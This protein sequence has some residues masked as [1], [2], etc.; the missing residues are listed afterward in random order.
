MP[1]PRL[2][3]Q[4]GIVATVLSLH[5]R[6][7]IARFL[8]P[9]INKVAK[10]NISPDALTVIGTVGTCTAA[11]Y[12]YPHGNFFWGT[13]VVTVFVLLDL[14]DG[15]L[16]RA[17]GTSSMWGAFLDSTLDRVGDGAIFSALAIWF[18]RDGR[19]LPLMCAALFCLVFGAVTSYSKARAESLGM[20]CNVGF[21]ER[22]ERLIAILVATGISG[23]GV[24][25]LLPTALWA[26]C[27]ATAITVVQRLVEVYRQASAL[28]DVAPPPPSTAVKKG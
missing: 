28:G 8:S 23:L 1:T 15:L 10:S 6:A 13:V 26:L 4:I 14:V 25:Y 18:A 20:T 3:S 5:V 9:A 2:F 17:K 7:P 24:P 11:L 21:A 19:S 16:A 12:F 22:A 27:A